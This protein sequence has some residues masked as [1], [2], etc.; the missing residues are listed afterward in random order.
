MLDHSTWVIQANSRCWSLQRFAPVVCGVCLFDLKGLWTGIWTLK[1]AYNITMRLKPVTERGI[2]C[3]DNLKLA[4]DLN[5]S[6]NTGT[7][8]EIY[9]PKQP[10][11]MLL[12]PWST[13]LLTHNCC[14][15][16]RWL[17]K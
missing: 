17:R 16:V 8:S 12:A 14:T 11:E 10:F 4:Y 13:W 2:W 5:F 7:S 3:V 1:C 9:D 6:N 15:L